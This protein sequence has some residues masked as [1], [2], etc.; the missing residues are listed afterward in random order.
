MNILKKILWIIVLWST[1][2]MNGCKESNSTVNKEKIMSKKIDIQGHRGC[3]GLYPENTIPAFEHALNLGVNTL[4]LDVVVSKDKQLIV[5][6]EPFFNHEIAMAPDGKAIPKEK[7]KEHNIYLLDYNEIKKYDVGTSY[8]EKFPEQKK[9]KVHKPSLTDMVKY[10]EAEA[11]KIG[12]QDIFYNIELKRRPEWDNSYLPSVNE[13]VDIAIK[14]VYDLGIETKTSLQCFDVPCLQIMHEKDPSIPLAY[15]IENKDSIEE[16][17]EKLGFVPAIYSPYYKLVDKDMVAYCNS[18][19]MKLIPW[20]TNELSDIN[21]MIDLQVDGIIS[22]YPDR[23]IKE[24][25]KRG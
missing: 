2:P 16:N 12:K 15:L 11:K 23:L 6:H 8:N 4:E 9:I 20:T 14:T 13:F 5:S 3:R 17:M 18:N 25:N 10:I 22:D 21:A 7:E 24:I 19:K 1:L